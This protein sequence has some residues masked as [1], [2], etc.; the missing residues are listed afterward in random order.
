VKIAVSGAHRT[1]KTTLVEGLSD[2]LPECVPVAEPYHLLEEEGHVFADVPAVEEFE[3]QLDRS[4]EVL[5]EPGDR[6]FDRCPVDVLAY[7]LTHPHAGAFDAEPWIPRVREAVGRLDVVAFVP[8]ERPDRVEV[9]DRDE[10]A[11]RRRV[12]EEL[13]DILLADRWELGVDVVEATGT[14]R[15]RVVQVLARVRP[16]RPGTPRPRRA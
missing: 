7:L 12:D 16:R 1:G 2:A 8:V 3:L 6:V 5:L 11:W 13:R 10:A 14:P 15:E 9:A 4:I